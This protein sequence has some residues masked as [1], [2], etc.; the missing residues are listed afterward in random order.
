LNDERWDQALYDFPDGTEFPYPGHPEELDQVRGWVC[1]LLASDWVLERWREGHWKEWKEIERVLRIHRPTP[2]LVERNQLALQFE[3]AD[4]YTLFVPHVWAFIELL[5]NPER[6]RLGLCERCNKFYVSKGR[7]RRKKFC[8][9]RCARNATVSRYIK[10]RR[11]ELRQAKINHAK[12]L[13]SGYKPSHGNWKRW[14]FLKTE[15]KKNQL[16][17]AFLSRAVSKGD[18]VNLLANPA[19]RPAGSSH[20]GTDTKG[21][22]DAAGKTR[23]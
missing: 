2:V 13:L 14:L 12:R 1:Q 8:S 19:R 17:P 23:L 3:R 9:M 7:Y 10:R 21:D 20:A 18:L 4:S 16:T 6:E 5:R 15:G 22:E 11:H